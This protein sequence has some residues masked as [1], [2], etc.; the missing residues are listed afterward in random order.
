M[1]KS[2]IL[3]KYQYYFLALLLI[4][5]FVLK[6]VYVYYFTNYTEYLFSDFGG[7]WARA[8]QR[9]SGEIF[10]VSQWAAWPPF[11]H[12]LL[13]WIFDAIS[14]FDMDEHRLKVVL[15]INITLSTI[16]AGLIYVISYRLYNSLYFAFLVVLTYM[17]YFPLIYFNAF[18]MS[19]HIGMFT[20][21][22]SVFLV[23]IFRDKK[24]MIFLAGIILAIGV[25]ARPAMG[26]FGLPFFLYIVFA[27]K[28]SFSSF[29]KGLIFSI[30]FFIVIFA[31]FAENNRISNGKVKTFSA[32]GG[33]NFY[34]SQCKTYRVDSVTDDGYAY[35]II[36]PA[37]V[38]EPENGTLKTDHPFYDQKYFFDMGLKCIEEN[39]YIWLENF[40][41][42]EVLFFGALL[43]SVEDA[44]YFSILLPIFQYLS[45]FASFTVLLLILFYKDNNINKPIL[46]LLVSILFVSLITMYF[47]NAEQRY[48]YSLWFGI[49]ILSILALYLVLKNFK[50]VYKIVFLY[51]SS[52][53]I[54][55]IVYESYLFLKPQKI[56]MIIS[57]NDK[58]IKSIYQTRSVSSKQLKH[59]DT[60]AFPSSSSLHHRTR[61][62]IGKFYNIFIDFEATMFLKNDKQ[63][64]FFIVSDDGFILLVDNKKISSYPS[65]RAAKLNTQSI[66]LKKGIHKIK[67]NY[68]QGVGNMAI[69]LLYEIDSKRYFVGED[70]KHVK[71]EER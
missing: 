9:H 59:I 8:L 48:F 38:Q 26:L 70:S 34:F 61:G 28:L 68:F 71:W 22:L 36:P 2:S 25:G 15:F 42:F 57:Q 7:Y 65:V 53:L 32:H 64:K 23:V 51:A 50:R 16:S 3:V 5:N 31:I 66:K 49:N 43:P 54:V 29:L 46:W 52:I 44:K 4:S 56:S 55:F 21:I 27:D 62:K 39:P 40:K 11:P 47:F 6:F 58:P 20:S 69:K 37:T 41:K 13:S 24:S 1:N 17:L 35:T 63:V 12:I 14:L 18:V 10:N 30:G 33:L 45:L 60:I 19:E 67:L